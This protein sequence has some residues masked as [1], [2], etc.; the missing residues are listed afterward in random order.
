MDKSKIVDALY[1]ASIYFIDNKEF[2]RQIT[3]AG[4]KSYLIDIFNY[5]IT[6]KGQP[7]ASIFKNNE[8][9]ISILQKKGQVVPLF[10][11]LLKKEGIT[12]YE[13]ILENGKML[14]YEKSG[15]EKILS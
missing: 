2:I 9:T 10:V 11:E 1:K 13:V 4:V 3:S 15:Q 8:I 6:F 7:A 14:Y 5:T 12:H